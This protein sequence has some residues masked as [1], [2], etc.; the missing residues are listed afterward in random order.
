MVIYME[1]KNTAGT[2]EFLFSAAWAVILLIIGKFIISLLPGYKII[3]TVITILMFCVLAFFALTRYS[4]VYTYTLTDERLRVN[5][6]IG[7]R[8]KEVSICITDIIRIAR[9]KPDNAP[10]DTQIMTK[11]VFSKKNA[12]Y[13]IY[14]KN[15]SAHMLVFE[16]SKAMAEA[17]KGLM[18]NPKA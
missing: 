11:T 5:R 7:H 12:Y 1:E 2:K 15:G 17:V 4:A 18:K 16:P 10:K 9:S 6:S 3:G 14:A 8:N 13:V